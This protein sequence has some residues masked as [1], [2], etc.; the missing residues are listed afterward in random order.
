M[1]VLKTIFVFILAGL[2]EIGDGYLIWQWLK[3]DKP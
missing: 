3:E 2:C 1:S